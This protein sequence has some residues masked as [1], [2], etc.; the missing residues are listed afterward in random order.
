MKTKVIF[1]K[2]S[3]GEVIAI[4][5]EELYDGINLDLVMSYLHIGQHG[6]ASK[7]LANELEI[8]LPEEY[9]DLYSELE[10]IGYDLEVIK[11]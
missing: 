6:A 11:E 8:A 10:S 9:D 4:F 5:P 1:R 2:F 3:D 7:S